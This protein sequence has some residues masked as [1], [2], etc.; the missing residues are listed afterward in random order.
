MTFERFTKEF[1]F[2]VQ[3]W[4]TLKSKEGD[5]D[6]TTYLNSASTRGSGYT[7]SEMEVMSS[8]EQRSLRKKQARK[9]MMISES[10]KDEEGLLD[11]RESPE[12][13]KDDEA[14]EDE[15]NSH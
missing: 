14:G 5:N 10:T 11:E 15:E 13:D 4:M 8:F 3:S 6:E 7:D 12:K 1:R 9:A 2:S